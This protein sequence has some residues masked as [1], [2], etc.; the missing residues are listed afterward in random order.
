MDAKVQ[1]Y[2]GKQPSIQQNICL[3]LREIILRALPETT[4]EMK[5]GVPVYGGGKIYIGSFKK[6]VNLGFSIKGLT[7]EEISLLEGT[8]KT[9]RHV[10]IHTL[11]EINEKK[12]VTLLHIVTR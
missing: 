8:G 7:K 5:W 9:M 12:I 10:K 6:N 11:E 4:E 2:I 1:E 3:K